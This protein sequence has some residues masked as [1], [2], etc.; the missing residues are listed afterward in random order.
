MSVEDLAEN[1]ADH[2]KPPEELDESDLEARIDLLEA[3]NERLRELYAQTR[4][5]AYRR[6][7]LGLAGIGVV[8][9]GGGFLFPAVRDVL[10]IL[11]AIG[12]FG[13]LLTYYLT[14]ERFVA[15][16]VAERVYDALATNEADLTADL[17]LS[18]DRVFLP[19][20]TTATLFVPQNAADP[21]PDSERIEGPLVVTEETRGLALV[22]SGARLFEEFDRT[23]SGPLADAPG[24]LAR[25]VTDALVEAFELV[26]GTDIDLDADDGRLT[27]GVRGSAYPDEFDSPP[28]SLLGVAIAVGLDRPIRVTTAPAEDVDF[29][30]T[31]RWDVVDASD[32]SAAEA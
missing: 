13:G 3:E 21:L 25:Q 12:L 4:R 2:D 17:G 10:F 26:D 8:A 27:V 14:P 11:A 28:A 16:D 29:T 15:A 7:A 19:D 5:S 22:P 32:T 6:T 31:C 18:D 24:P 23:L 1:G 9:A 30:V 20:D